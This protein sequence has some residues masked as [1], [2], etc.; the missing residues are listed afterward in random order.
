MPKNNSN[1]QNA[2]ARVRRYFP[3]VEEVEDGLKPLE[4]EVTAKDSKS[5]AVRNHQG[6]AMAVACKRLTKADGVIV[7]ISTAYIIK[8]KTA[9]RYSVPQHVQR[10]IVSFD[11]EA[12]FAEG[13]YRLVPKEPSNRLDEPKPTGPHKVTGKLRKTFHYTAG[14]RTVL[15]SENVR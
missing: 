7:S 8:G 14:I 1:H 5:A 11:R 13:N 4:V 3:Q 9:T 6:C 15:G 10:E 2:L 12:G